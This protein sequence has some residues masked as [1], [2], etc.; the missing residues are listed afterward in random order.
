MRK[1]ITR[2]EKEW[3]KYRLALKGLTQTDIVDRTGCS[4]PIVTNVIAGRKVSVNVTTVLVKALGFGSFDELIAAANQE[5]M[6]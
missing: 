3:I 6:A 1:P 5:G 2:R 4:R